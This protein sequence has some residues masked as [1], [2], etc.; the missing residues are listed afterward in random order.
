VDYPGGVV[1]VW[2][3]VTGKQLTRIETGYGYRSVAHKLF[4]S[5]DW[6]TVYVAREKRQALPFEKDGKKWV[7]W[8]MDGDVR[9][10]DLGTG[11][12]R[13]TFRH[14]PPRGVSAMV[15][16]PDGST[17][18]TFEGVSGES[19]RGPAKAASLWDVKARKSRPLPANLNYWAVY[20]P[21]GK[22]LAAPAEDANGRTNAI[23]LFDVTSAREKLAIPIGTKEAGFGYLALAPGGKLLVGQVR[24]KAGH[25]LKLWDPATGREVG[26]LAGEKGDL[27]LWMAFSPDG[28]T[29]AVTNSSR[30]RQGK[31]FLFDLP[32]RRLVKSV[33]L[34]A[35]AA[36]F[37]PAF[38][39]DGRWVA[40]VAQGFPDDQGPLPKAE[41][42][43]Q[44]RIHLIDAASGAVRE[45][46][47]APQGI[48]RSVCFSPDG[49]TLATGGHGKVLLWDLT[50]PPG[51]PDQARG[52]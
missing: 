9:A 23:E 35:K 27:F 4:V 21:D 32:G 14:D 47:V 33:V 24:A 6:K 28:R 34:G 31:L 50:K 25:W 7:R 26:S 8:D 40:A 52:Q 37:P 36:V 30:S 39:P 45:T 22:T 5:P 18:A 44:P 17:F 3:A 20:T 10:W 29:L 19:E 38:S 41:D 12:L 11:E 1:Q 16:S 43:P 15:L 13:H 51:A 46:I 2:D 49:K 48:T 42:S